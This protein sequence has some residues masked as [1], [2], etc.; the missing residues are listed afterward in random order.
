MNSKSEW[1]QAG[2]PRLVTTMPNQK[3]PGGN[4]AEDN[5]PQYKLY[6][7]AI[8]ASERTGSKRKTTMS[9]NKPEPGP[10]LQPDQETG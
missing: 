4:P 6:L 8:A 3:R 7:A 9:W 2:V 1:G 10:R 5:N